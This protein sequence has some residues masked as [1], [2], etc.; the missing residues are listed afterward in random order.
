MAPPPKGVLF[1]PIV[2][3]GKGSSKVLLEFS[4]EGGV[5]KTRQ[6]VL[7]EVTKWHLIPGFG[8]DGSRALSQACANTEKCKSEWQGEGDWDLYIS[9]QERQGR[10]EQEI[11]RV[12]DSPSA[13]RAIEILKMGMAIQ[14][15][16]VNGRLEGFDFTYEQA[17]VEDNV[18]ESITVRLMRLDGS[19]LEGMTYR[20]TLSTLRPARRGVQGTVAQ[21]LASLEVRMAGI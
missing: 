11:L 8:E 7:E 20:W 13:E 14:D 2:D 1:G 5:R 12:R 9:Q 15:S 10:G 3:W 18:L 19:V 4:D 21:D 17:E 6:Y 16:S